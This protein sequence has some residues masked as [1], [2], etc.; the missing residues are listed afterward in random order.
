MS[1]GFETT[2]AT[3]TEV[4]I[5]NF[6]NGIRTSEVGYNFSI[7]T[8]VLRHNRRAII[9]QSYSEK[10]FTVLFRKISRVFRTH[11]T[12]KSRL[13]SKRCPTVT[14]L[15]IAQ[16]TDLPAWSVEDI[17]RSMLPQNAPLIHVRLDTI[18]PVLRM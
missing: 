15:P 3:E 9:K 17:I 13:F 8:N 4:K 2:F 12:R 14:I 11:P 10:T 16:P 7:Q 6:F 18:Y 1:G 5:W